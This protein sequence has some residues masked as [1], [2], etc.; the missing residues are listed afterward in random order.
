[1]STFVHYNVFVSEMAP[2]KHPWMLLDKQAVNRGSTPLASEW[3]SRL[4]LGTYAPNHLNIIY[5]E[6][7]R[8]HLLSKPRVLIC[9]RADQDAIG[10]SAA[11]LSNLLRLSRRGRCWGDVPHLHSNLPGIALANKNF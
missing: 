6:D 11:R 7:E 10:R 2:I 3:L 9:H 5:R 4:L 1:M 8:Q